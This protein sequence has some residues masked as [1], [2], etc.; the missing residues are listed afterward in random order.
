MFES[1][2]GVW[3]R[4]GAQEESGARL[5]LECR[6][7]RRFL[8]I[9]LWLSVYV[10][11]RRRRATDIACASLGAQE[12]S[13]ARLFLEAEPAARLV[14]KGTPD[15]RA[16]ARALVDEALARNRFLF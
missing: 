3:V 10:C 12:E 14:V 1:A 5:F 9:S 13:G 15:E 4:L 16:R 11:E 2:G 8:R 7:L 6:E